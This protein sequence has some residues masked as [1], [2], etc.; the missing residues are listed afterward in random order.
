MVDAQ[1]ETGG[2]SQGGNL[3][4]TISRILRYKKHPVMK[5]ENASLSHREWLKI[6]EA[7]LDFHRQ[8]TLDGLR[9]SIVQW[10]KQLIA[11]DTASLCDNRGGFDCIPW[12]D[13]SADAGTVQRS[14]IPEKAAVGAMLVAN[15]GRDIFLDRSELVRLWSSAPN[16]PDP[17]E[18]PHISVQQFSQYHT[19]RE[20]RQTQLYS[21]CYAPV[22][23]EMWIGVE[24]GKS[25][26]TVA[27]SRKRSEF[28][29]AE[30]LTLELLRPQIEIAYQ[31]LLVLTKRTDSLQPEFLREKLASFGIS[32]REAEVLYWLTEG[33]TNPEIGI[34]LNM[35]RSTVKTHLLKIY[36]KIGCETR[37]AAT[38]WVF[39]KI[40]A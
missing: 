17:S 18:I 20:F 36:S 12:L 35:A 24:L 2:R 37:T 15:Y 16:V 23:Q 6:H 22:D 27:V 1:G 19:T 25:K 4:L 7:T 34:I 11:S 38:R 26:L 13:L 30:M 33:K 28:S 21:E 10:A 40:G 5:L 3:Q 29:D 31:R 8:T 14:L 9:M 32:Q 39:E